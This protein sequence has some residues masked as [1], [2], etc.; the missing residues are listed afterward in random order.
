MHRE[1]VDQPRYCRGMGRHP[2]T[3]QPPSALTPSSNPNLLPPTEGVQSAPTVSSA[4][5]LCQRCQQHLGMRVTQLASF[6]PTSEVLHSCPAGHRAVVTA[7]TN[8]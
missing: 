7:T 4:Q 3:H 5:L 8:T 6:Q 1:G 2:P